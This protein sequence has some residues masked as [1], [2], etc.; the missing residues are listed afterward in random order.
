[1]SGQVSRGSAGE[2]QADE[3]ARAGIPMADAEVAMI[4]QTTV[5]LTSEEDLKKFQKTMDLLDEDD[6]VQQVYTNIDE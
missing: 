5:A 2:Y 4:P 6:D 1:M 3:R